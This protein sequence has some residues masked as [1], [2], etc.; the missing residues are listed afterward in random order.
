MAA[1]ADAFA[2]LAQLDVPALV[3]GGHALQAYGLSRPTFDV[4]CLIASSN[5]EGL[6][7][8]LVRFN[9]LW[10]AEFDAFTE[11]RHRG[12]M[13]SIPVHVMH[14]DVGT[15]GRGGVRKI[16]GGEF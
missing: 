10:M 4:D 16:L 7:S 3:I 15:W 1:L 8:A 5:K 11:Y 14:V 9:F 13:D 2:A 12:R 6:R